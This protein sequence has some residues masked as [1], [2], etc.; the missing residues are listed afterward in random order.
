VQIGQDRV[1]EFN[2]A[3]L[4]LGSTNHGN[5]QTK[6]TG[7]LF[8]FNT[9]VTRYQWFIDEVNVWGNFN[10]LISPI[11]CFEVEL[12]CVPVCHPVIKKTCLKRL[13]NNN[14]LHKSIKFLLWNDTSEQFFGVFLFPW[15]KWYDSQANYA[16]TAFCY[17][18]P[19]HYL[20]MILLFELLTALFNKP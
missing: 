18:F 7:F 9:R 2:D 14:K 8:W 6:R 11:L 19:R 1:K 10:C 5:E 15:R 20:Q 12:Q 3:N 16:T 4:R 17:S 13:W